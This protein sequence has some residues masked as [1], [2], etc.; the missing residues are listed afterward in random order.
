MLWLPAVKDAIDT[1][2]S[3]LKALQWQRK[4][5][6]NVCDNAESLSTNK[7]QMSYPKASTGTL[8]C[9]LDKDCSGIISGIVPLRSHS[10]ETSP[11]VFALHY[12]KTFF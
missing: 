6:K 7:K 4:K 2:L 11:E 5:Q 12:A 1:V 10:I 9:F 3:K 8:V